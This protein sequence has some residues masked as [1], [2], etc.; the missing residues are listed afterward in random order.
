MQGRIFSYMD[1]QL[2]RHNGPN[3]EQLPINRPRVPVHSNSRDGAGESDSFVYLSMRGIL[4][5]SRPNV[6]STQRSR[7]YSK[8]NQRGI[9]S[10]SHPN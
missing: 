3:F 2:N 10:T 5:L 9:S 7:L 8:Y 6:Y 1:T 4:T